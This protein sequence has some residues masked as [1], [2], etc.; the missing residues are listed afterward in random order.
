MILSIEGITG[1]S[2]AAQRVLAV[3][4]G[5]AQVFTPSTSVFSFTKYSWVKLPRFTERIKYSVYS[6]FA[7]VGMHLFTN[8]LVH[9]LC[10]LRILF[11]L[12]IKS[13]HHYLESVCI[14]NKNISYLPTRQFNL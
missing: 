2:Q 14:Y 13:N 1:L 11:V 7:V 3:P 12:K 9:I 6:V 4:L 10:M 8:S 5:S